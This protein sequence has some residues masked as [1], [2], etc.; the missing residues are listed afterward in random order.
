VNDFLPP[1]TATLFV[2]SLSA[3]IWIARNHERDEPRREV[4][5]NGLDLLLILA[6]WILTQ[7]SSILIG[8]HWSGLEIPKDSAAPS[9]ELQTVLIT[10]NLVGSLTA[11]LFAVALLVLRRQAD[12]TDLGIDLGHVARDIGF[13]AI[14]FSAIA[15]IVYAVQFLTERWVAEYKHPL[16]DALHKHG[17]PLT[18]LIVAAAALVVAPIWEEFLFRVVLQGWLEKLEIS[19]AT[20]GAAAITISSAIFALVHWGQGAA[21]IPLFIFALMLGYLYHKTHRL[22]PSVTAH[23]LLNAVSMAMLAV[24]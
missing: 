13:G 12:R 24:G 9:P 7:Q 15:P 16:I 5:W 11:M 8:L 10:S 21:P 1:I 19:R 20:R 2:L 17:T 23:F 6:V 14:A 18:W 4:P 3:W 22:I